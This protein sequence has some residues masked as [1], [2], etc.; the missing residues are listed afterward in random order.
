M[1]GPPEPFVAF[2]ATGRTEPE[3]VARAPD[4]RAD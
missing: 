1:P 3:D 2:V 4:T